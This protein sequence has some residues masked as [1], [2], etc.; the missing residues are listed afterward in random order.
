MWSIADPWKGTGVFWAEESL[1]VQ[2]SPV[3]GKSVQQRGPRV[4]EW[5]ALLHQHYQ[6]TNTKEKGGFDKNQKSCLQVSWEEKKKK[7]LDNMASDGTGAI[8]ILLVHGL[9][10]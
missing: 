4:P 10:L 5:S 3:R 6:T 8:C 2:H 1:H 7:A 9:S